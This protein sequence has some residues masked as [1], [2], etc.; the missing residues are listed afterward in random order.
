M[1]IGRF[2]ANIFIRITRQINR[3]CNQYINIAPRFTSLLDPLM[4]NP[5]T[6]G[7]M[8]FPRPGHKSF[9]SPKKNFFSLLH[10]SVS[11][12]LSRLTILSSVFHRPLL[13][14]KFSN[15][16]ISFELSLLPIL[17]SVYHRAPLVLKFSHL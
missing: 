13:D 5:I 6:L 10:R 2:Y 8:I 4:F 12:V 7:T 14:L 11:F 16:Y 3:F 17:S 1:R 9:F 15:F